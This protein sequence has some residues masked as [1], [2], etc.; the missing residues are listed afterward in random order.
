MKITKLIEKLGS[1]EPN[2]KQFFSIYINAEAGQNGRD[3][4]PIWLK[5]ELSD[6]EQK[7]K[8]DE[9]ELGRF[10]ALT[11]RINNFVE[12]EADPSANGIA[13][14]ASLGEGDYFEV[15]QLDVPFPESRFHSS[16]R[17]HIFPLARA[18]HEN[19]RYAVLW[20]DKNKADIYVFGGETRIRSDVDA[21]SKVESIENEVTSGT[22]AGGWSQQRFQRRRENFALQHAKEVVAEL[23]EVMK[24]YSVEHLIIAGDEE[25]IL[26]VIK[27]ELSKPLED[28]LIGSVSIADYQSEDDIREKTLDVVTT[29]MATLQMKEVERVN[30]ATKAAAKLGTLGVEDTLRALAN[31]QVEELVI[32][33][34]ID[35]IDY[36]KKKIKK[37][38]NEYEPGDD[39]APTDATVNVSDA[40]EIA[41][42]LVMRAINT[43]AK[44]MFVKDDSLLEDAGGV[45]SILRFNMNAQAGG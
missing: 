19:P 35:S 15:V 41:D 7:Y 23:E 27:P 30:D 21:Q 14:F 2:G 8:D 43:A 1:M 12:N 45:G 6:E 17:P 5:T 29:E 38:L 4:Y 25:T 13:I 3:T 22:S 28:K 42:Q 18:V 37:I 40:A 34:N 39:T 44:I 24:K 36:S 20:A 10:T 11:E 9:A 16:D 31:G 32:A 33:S 26:P